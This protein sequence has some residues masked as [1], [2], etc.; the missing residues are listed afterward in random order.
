MKFKK[1]LP[2]ERFVLETSLSPTEVLD[3]ISGSIQPPKHFFRPGFLKQK[4]KLYE[5]AIIFPNKFKINR[6]INY[7]NSFLP[8]IHG[9]VEVKNEKTEVAVAMR[10]FTFSIVFMMF[11]L[12]AAAFMCIAIT[13]AA[14]VQWREVLKGGISLV[15]LIPF[16]MFTLG[17]GMMMWG[18]KSESNEAKKFLIDLLSAKIL[19]Y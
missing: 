10:L 15:I 7:R 17:Y 1:F 3:R 4:G 14:F 12:G 8:V 2:Y 11:W 5:G 19:N 6:L 9:L 16:A 13:V 18:F